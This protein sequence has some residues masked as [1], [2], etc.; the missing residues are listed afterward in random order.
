M[1]GGAVKARSVRIDLLIERE[2]L[3]ALFLNDHPTTTLQY[4]LAEAL[5]KIDH[6]SKI[7]IAARK[8]AQTTPGRRRAGAPQSKNARDGASQEEEL[9]NITRP[10][11]ARPT[12]GGAMSVELS[13]GT[14]AS[15]P[16]VPELL[17]AVTT[18]TT[19]DD[20][21]QAFRMIWVSRKLTESGLALDA[22]EQLALRAIAIADQATEP[23]NSMRDAPLLDREGRRKVF[24]GRAYDAL[25]LYIA[26]YEAGSPVSA[27]RRAQI[28]SLYKK[29]NGSLAGLDEKLRQE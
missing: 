2:R 12:D 3:A 21:R 28:E 11:R 4:R 13:A 1:L 29:L 5:A 27:V 15:L 22:A 10:R 14:D 16:G 6:Y 26:S 20:G 8:P 23:A 7:A 18:F 24:L 17:K 19:L 9:K 25:D